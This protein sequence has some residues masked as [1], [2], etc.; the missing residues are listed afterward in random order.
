LTR[1]L[2][3]EGSVLLRRTYQMQNLMSDKAHYR[4]RRLRVIPLCPP[5]PCSGR[6]GDEHG[7]DSS[8]THARAQSNA[9]PFRP[10]AALTLANVLYEKKE[11]DRVRHGQPAEVAQCSEYTTWE[12]PADRFE[13]NA[14]DTT[15]VA[16]FD[17]RGQKSLQPGRHRRSR[18][19]DRESSRTIQPFGQT[20]LDLSRISASGGR[21]V[22][23]S[24]S[25]AAARTADGG[26]IRD[27]WKVEVRPAEVT[28]GPSGGGGTARLRGWSQGRRSS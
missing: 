12:G 3:C 26:T 22:N 6:T 17:E 25:A 20:V 21:A 28:L 15:C 4:P 13:T 16:S 2:R 24:R 18:A 10:T 9:D 23:G 19:C 7:F 8:N 27:V 11:C 1:L 5:V 14:N